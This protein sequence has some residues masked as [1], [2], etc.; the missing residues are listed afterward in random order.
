MRGLIKR[1]KIRATM[2]SIF[3]DILDSLGLQW[4]SIRDFLGIS[5]HLTGKNIAIA[6]VDG[7]FPP[8][9]FS[10]LMGRIAIEKHQLY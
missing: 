1:E 4:P 3:F 6:V 7:Y 10:Q 5:S 2:F 9:P 8:L